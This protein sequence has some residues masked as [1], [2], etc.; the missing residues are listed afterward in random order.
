MR[1]T[2]LDFAQMYRQHMAEVGRPKSSDAWDARAAELGVDP[3][4]G[5]YGQTL[6]D[7]MDLSDCQS[8]LDVGCGGGAI[9]VALAR[10]LAS[11]HGID[12]SAKML[13]SLRQLA[14]SQSIGNV[15]CQLKSWDDDWHDVPVCDVVLA[16]RSTAVM[17]MEQ[18][19]AK[20]RS[21]ARKR[22]YLTSLVGGL[23]AEARLLNIIQRKRVEPL[24]DPLYVVNILGQMGHQPTLD[25][26]TS[27]NR[28]SGASDAASFIQQ[29][30]SS[31]GPL[32][33]SEQGHLERWMDEQG[34]M[35]AID[36]AIAHQWA[37][38]SF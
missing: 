1:L 5:H 22:V 18:A 11:V 13:D 20:L 38:I 34:S 25:Y 3:S 9:T 36:A 12:F 33:G 7:K 30:A 24:P 16:S 29:V 27:T 37:L 35:A 15:S 8:L 6:I 31:L 17:D 26:I 28:Y 21:K 4:L 14:Q 23:F 2:D 32:S 10:R 19:L